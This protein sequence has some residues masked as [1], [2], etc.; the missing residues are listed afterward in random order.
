MLLFPGFCILVGL[1]YGDLLRLLEKQ[2]MSAILLTIVTVLVI[3]PS[4]VFDVAYAP[5]PWTKRTFAQRFAR[6]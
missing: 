3:A 1:T 4:V 5:T 2:R 6:T